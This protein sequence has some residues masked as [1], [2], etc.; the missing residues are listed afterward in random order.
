MLPWCCSAGWPSAAAQLQ[1][2]AVP[3]PAA[4][5]TAVALESEST[6]VCEK[7]TDRETK[8]EMRKIAQIKIS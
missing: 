4:A 7:E 5:T 1:P 8:R 6:T 2:K 3:G